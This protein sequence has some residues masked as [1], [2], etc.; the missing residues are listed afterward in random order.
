[1]RPGIRF[2]LSAIEKSDVWS[3]WKAGESLHEIGRAYIGGILEMANRRLYP[4]WNHLTTALRSGLPQN[5]I[6]DGSSNPFAV[7][8]AEPT[9]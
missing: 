2:G 4:F 1:M 5:E 7:I 9:G 6:R 8:Y 3:R